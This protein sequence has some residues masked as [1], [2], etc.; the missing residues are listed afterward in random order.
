MSKK[1][2][3]GKCK[4][5]LK[6]RSYGHTKAEAV[7]T[8][9]INQLTQSKNLFLILHPHIGLAQECF[10][11]KRSETKNVEFRRR[12]A[13][14][15]KI[16]DFFWSSTFG[17]PFPNGIASFPFFIFPN[18]PFRK[19]FQLKNNWQCCH[20]IITI[21]KEGR[22]TPLLNSTFLDQTYFLT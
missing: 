7:I 16:A 15:A 5:A 1:R 6:R 14:S 13:L 19:G 12:G 9:E 8:L 4:I 17:Y 22:M 3:G 11:F 20:I 2:C 21:A 18:K 10:T